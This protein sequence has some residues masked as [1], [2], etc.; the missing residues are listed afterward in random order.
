MLGVAFNTILLF[1]ALLRSVRPYA[2]NETA[3][4][5]FS[6]AASNFIVVRRNGRE[7]FLYTIL[8]AN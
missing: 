8:P 2:T 6:A 7:E 3:D 1:V 5:D 4:S